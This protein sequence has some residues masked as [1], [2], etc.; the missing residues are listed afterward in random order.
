MTT[1]QIGIWY[2]DIFISNTK[3]SIIERDK[4]LWGITAL[5]VACKYNEHDYNWPKNKDFQRISRRAVFPSVLVTCFEK[6][7]CTT[8]DWNLMVKPPYYYLEAFYSDIENHSDQVF[9]KYWRLYTETALK[10]TELQKYS[11]FEQYLA[12]LKLSSQISDWQWDELTHIISCSSSNADSINDIITVLKQIDVS[13]TKDYNPI[14]DKRK[15]VSS[16][17]ERALFND[18]SVSNSRNQR[19][20]RLLKNNHRIDFNAYSTKDR[21]SS[22]ITNNH[23]IS[24]TTIKSFKDILNDYRDNQ[25]SSSLFRTIDKRQNILKDTTYKSRFS[26]N[27]GDPKWETFT[28]D[29][30]YYIDYL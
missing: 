9:D 6:E 21:S 28:R 3:I 2:I 29:S 10:S 23:E 13:E 22:R 8:L 12:V 30:R 25:S 26:K 27:N 17:R 1:I 15:Y 20:K 19:S 11:Y 7:L 5:L 24:S 14:H 18:N 4:Y 16:R